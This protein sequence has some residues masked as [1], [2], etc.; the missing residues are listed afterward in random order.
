MKSEDTESLRS[1][2]VVHCVQARYML[3]HVCV[4]VCLSPSWVTPASQNGWTDQ[5]GF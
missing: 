2:F 5:A 3:H 4:S 1:L